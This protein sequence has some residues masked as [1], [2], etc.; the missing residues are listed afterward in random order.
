MDFVTGLLL[1]TDWKEDSYNSIFVIVN[2]MTK[3]MHYEPIKVTIDRAGLAEIILNV[4]V[5]HHSLSDSIVTNK[6]LFFIS[7]FL[8][9]LCYFF[10]IKQRLSTVFHPQIN[11]Q[12]K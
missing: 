12:T 8:L 7:K 6:G 10:G 11:G 4:V 1:S 2:Q 5:W 9:L 3:M